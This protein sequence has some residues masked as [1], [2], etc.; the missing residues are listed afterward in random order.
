MIGDFQVMFGNFKHVLLPLGVD[1]YAAPK[2]KKKKVAGV[3]IQ[4]LSIR[5]ASK[6]ETYRVNYRPPIGSPGRAVV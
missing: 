1:T 5:N 2:A 6:T 3:F 4:P